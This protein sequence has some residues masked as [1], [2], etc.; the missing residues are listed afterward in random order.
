MKV[1]CP[2]CGSI[3]EFSKENIFRPF[4]SERCRLID[5]G[6]WASEEYKIPIKHDSSNDLLMALSEDEQLEVQS[7]IESR[8]IEMKK[9]VD[10]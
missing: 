10:E 3:C 7:H 4:C 6:M 5:L 8:K 9:T 1:N 2:N